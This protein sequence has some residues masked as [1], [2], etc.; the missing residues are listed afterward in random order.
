MFW[1][2]GVSFRSL[3]ETAFPEDHHGLELDP[4][5][6]V[7]QR[8]RAGSGR[9]VRGQLR[10]SLGKKPD[11]CSGRLM[12]AQQRRQPILGRAH[13]S[14]M[15]SLVGEP[16]NGCRHVC[17]PETKEAGGWDCGGRW[18]MDVFRLSKDHMLGFFHAEVPPRR[19]CSA[20]NAPGSVTS[21]AQPG[22]QGAC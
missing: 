3:S 16:G 12:V 22:L 19:C 15:G 21:A 11:T 20:G 7:P 1:P 4:T 14:P 13:A 2:G 17:E 6:W 10:P 5:G 18:L 9:I 8:R